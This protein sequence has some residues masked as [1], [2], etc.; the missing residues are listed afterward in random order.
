MPGSKRTAEN[1]AGRVIVFRISD[2]LRG[3]A[4]WELA[5]FGPLRQVLDGCRGVA[6]AHHIDEELLVSNGVVRHGAQCEGT[7]RR[8]ACGQA[9]GLRSDRDS[10]PV[11]QL[12]E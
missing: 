3:A 7:V 4:V 9:H 5:A 1:I 10:L 8:H 11:R 12:R 2:G 6:V